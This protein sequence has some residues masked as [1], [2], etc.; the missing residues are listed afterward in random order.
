MS[1]LIE[2]IDLAVVNIEN[3]KKTD[4]FVRNP[5]N[6]MLKIKY[7]RLLNISQIKDNCNAFFTKDIA[8]SIFG[9]FLYLDLVHVLLTTRAKDP[10]DREHK[11]AFFQFSRDAVKER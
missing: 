4:L 3:L 8:W 1:S 7:I 5:M 6:P 2:N 10:T 11:I 9:S